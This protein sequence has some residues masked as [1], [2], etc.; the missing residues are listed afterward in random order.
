MTRQAECAATSEVKRAVTLKAG[1]PMNVG[2]TPAAAGWLISLPCVSTKLTASRL[3]FL[4]SAARWL[5]LPLFLAMADGVASKRLTV[6]VCTP[7]MPSQ[8]E[9][10]CNWL[11]CWR[12]ASLYA[13]TSGSQPSGHWS[14]HG[15]HWLASAWFSVGGS[16]TCVNMSCW[17]VRDRSVF[18]SLLEVTIGTKTVTVWGSVKIL[19][20][21]RF[22]ILCGSETW[23]RSEG[24]QVFEYEVPKKIL[25][26]S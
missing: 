18:C 6:A 22:C 15:P 2:E 26:L 14:C 23:S 1:H 24:V 16:H 13:V 3:V 7:D 12:S 17:S 11:V 9:P 25:E 19:Y 4:V 8:C 10:S 20:G 5:S 21:G